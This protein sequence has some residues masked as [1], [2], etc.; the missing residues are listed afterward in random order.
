M[1]C[2][3]LGLEL[4][5]SY[6]LKHL[7][8]LAS[9]KNEN[10]KFGWDNDSEN[11]Y[12]IGGGISK[13]DYLGLGNNLQ[14]LF[15]TGA[16]YFS[17]VENDSTATLSHIVTILASFDTILDRLEAD[18]TSD[19]PTFIHEDLIE[20]EKLKIA[21]IKLMEVSKLLFKI[22]SELDKL[23]KTWDE[24]SVAQQVTAQ[25]LKVKEQLNRVNKFIDISYSILPQD[26][27][28]A[29]LTCGMFNSCVQM[30]DI[31]S[32]PLPLTP[33]KHQQSTLQSQAVSI[34]NSIFQ[35]C[36]GNEIYLPAP[37]N[38]ESLEVKMIRNTLKNPSAM[39]TGGIIHSFHEYL[40][41]CLLKSGLLPIRERIPFY[42]ATN[43]NIN[44]F[45]LQEAINE[46][47]TGAIDWDLNSAISIPIVFEDN[48][49]INAKHIA[50]ILITKNCVEYFDPKGICSKERF[51]KGGNESICHFL[52]FCRDKYT[53]NG[54]IIE[55][56][57][58]LQQ[59]SHNCGVFCCDLLERRLI[60]REVAGMQPLKVSSEE[61][62]MMRHSIFQGIKRLY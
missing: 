10:S 36:W 42:F 52:E 29:S 59:D 3:H 2:N 5:N 62:A 45:N 55:N 9:Y 37:E 7:I 53:Q 58:V 15:Q 16:R 51:L 4:F 25:S 14:A 24:K 8:F 33:L 47:G 28:L 20:I 18:L 27:E 26:H 21:A 60:Q 11:L 34:V 54:R 12:L 61:L 22:P 13:D 23:K 48:H 39:L 40:N 56:F 6:D 50:T 44:Q 19:K 35:M 41:Q 57:L 49:L 46:L 38:N 31:S 43:A 1:N 17:N 30:D 32:Q